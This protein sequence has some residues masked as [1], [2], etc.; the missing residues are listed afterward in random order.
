MNNL[1]NS[2]NQECDKTYENYQR[3]HFILYILSILIVI[4]GYKTSITISYGSNTLYF[5]WDPI[6]K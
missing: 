6:N 2:V 1:V 4:T 5:K 3:T